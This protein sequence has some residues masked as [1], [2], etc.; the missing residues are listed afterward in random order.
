MC[1][2]GSS[3][4]NSNVDF[5]KFVRNL[6]Q[7]RRIIYSCNRKHQWHAGSISFGFD[8]NVSP[9]VFYNQNGRL[10]RLFHW[11]S[12]CKYLWPVGPTSSGLIWNVPSDVIH[13]MKFAHQAQQSSFCIRKSEFIS[14]LN[15]SKAIFQWW[16]VAQ[17]YICKIP[18]VIVLQLSRSQ[19]CLVARLNFYNWN[20]RMF[21]FVDR[22]LVSLQ[23]L[24]CICRFFP[25]YEIIAQYSL[26]IFY[27]YRT[28][29]HWFQ[30][31][32]IGAPNHVMIFTV[33]AITKIF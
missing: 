13:T 8:L 33:A 11:L 20:V 28:K 5:K 22:K 25:A 10:V 15:S 30:I 6:W 26:T 19:M 7:L 1:P 16:R 21:E 14:H 27:N 31:T 9:P 2:L 29:L 4:F 17:M 18:I 32:I 12:I 24:D 23:W 3:A